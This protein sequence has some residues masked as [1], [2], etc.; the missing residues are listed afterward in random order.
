MKCFSGLSYLFHFV[1]DRQRLTPLYK[2]LMN[3][4]Q[5]QHNLKK[6][7]NAFTSSALTIF[8]HV[9]SFTSLEPD[10]CCCKDGDL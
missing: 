3:Y 4:F 9:T 1:N 7:Y 10:V 8:G 2:L 5:N 6:H